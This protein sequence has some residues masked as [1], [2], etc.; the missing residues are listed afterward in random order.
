MMQTAYS[1]GSGKPDS[2]R[3]NIYTSLFFEHSRLSGHWFFSHTCRRMS[4]RIRMFFIFIFSHTCHFGQKL[5]CDVS[6]R[7]SRVKTPSLLL[8]RQANSNSHKLPQTPTNSDTHEFR[9]LRVLRTF[10]SKTRPTPS[11]R[12]W[13]YRTGCSVRPFAPMSTCRPGSLAAGCHSLEQKVAKITKMQS[14][15]VSNLHS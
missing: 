4:S 15:Y 11:I 2:L 12:C 7:S 13:A 10:C 6:D 8:K 3:S 1:R 5:A 14:R 9:S